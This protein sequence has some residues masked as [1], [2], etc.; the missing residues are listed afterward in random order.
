METERSE[1]FWKDVSSV[2]VDSVSKDVEQ[3]ENEKENWNTVVCRD[4]ANGI[5]VKVNAL[6]QLKKDDK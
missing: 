6:L 2:L 4:I 5:A 3:Y 1:N